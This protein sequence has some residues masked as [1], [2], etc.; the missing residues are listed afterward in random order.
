MTRVAAC[1]FEPSVGDVAENRERIA[2]F[3]ARADADVAV[4]PE[5]CLTGYDLDT[6]L[7]A[8]APVDEH[9][10]P[11]TDVAGDTDTHLVVGLP[12]RDG[13][14]VYN[15]VA[16]VTPEGVRA[17]YRKRHPWGDEADVFDSGDDAV[18]VETPA[19]TMGLLVCY[20]LNFPERAV[21]YAREECDVLAV[22]TAWRAS[23]HDDWALLCRARALDGT[24][25]VVGANHAGDQRGRVHEGGSLVAGPEGA[26][27]D[28]VAD[29]T[30]VAAAEVSDGALA[31]ARERNPVFEARRGARTDGGGLATPPGVESVV[32]ER[33]CSNCGATAGVDGGTLHC[34]ACGWRAHH[35][36]D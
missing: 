35:P 19:G 14:S 36:S 23:Y 10:A 11:L 30:A 13:E 25:F 27:L 22:S 32:G 18:T 1:Q 7:D 2:A 26:V 24:C 6:A 20:D 28:R 12:E 21:E 33:T 16:Y 4:L 31:A 9:A 17:T 8:A 5:L 29:G 3:A 15:A 34:P